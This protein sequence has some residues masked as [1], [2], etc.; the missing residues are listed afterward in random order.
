MILQ[1]SYVVQAAL[2]LTMQLWILNS[3]FSAYTALGLVPLCQY[4]SML[5]WASGSQQKGWQELD[6]R[7]QK[8]SPAGR[9]I[10]HQL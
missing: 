4:E 3:G 10:G 7:L 8:K 9:K 6:A 2:H 5:I 1:Q